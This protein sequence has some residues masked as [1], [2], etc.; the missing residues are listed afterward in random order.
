MHR[1]SSLLCYLESNI[2]T[3]ESCNNEITFTIEL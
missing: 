3:K 1:Y 2:K